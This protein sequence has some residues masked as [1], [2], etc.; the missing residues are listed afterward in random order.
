ME[1]FG[2]RRPVVFE[3]Q[4]GYGQPERAVGSSCR[5]LLDVD[6]HA[7]NKG[8][9]SPCVKIPENKVARTIGHLSPKK[10]VGNLK[11]ATSLW[12]DDVAL[13]IDA[14]A[15]AIDELFILVWG[16]DQLNHGIR[17]LKFGEL[18]VANA[19]DCI[20]QSDGKQQLLLHVNAIFV[21]FYF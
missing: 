16:A 1:L 7:V 20:K 14:I 8:S 10:N 3:G 2:V 21:D 6:G 15:H 9:Y 13:L 5:A 4:T 12:E 18:R 11:G 17:H 19:V